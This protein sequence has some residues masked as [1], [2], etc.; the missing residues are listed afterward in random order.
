MKITGTKKLLILFFALT[1][2]LASALGVVIT[3][4]SASKGVAYAETAVS[5]PDV[6]EVTEEIAELEAEE[7]SK[8]DTFFEEEYDARYDED[9]IRKVAELLGR[10]YEAINLYC[11]ANEIDARELLA[12]LLEDE[13]KKAAEPA[14]PSFSVYVGHETTGEE[15]VSPEGTSNYSEDEAW[16]PFEEEEKTNADAIIS[17]LIDFQIAYTDG[18]ITLPEGSE[19]NDW[20]IAPDDLTT[21]ATTYYFMGYNFSTA[22]SQ[23]GWSFSSTQLRN[24][25]TIHHPE[26][27]DRLGG[28]W[29]SL[30]WQY[31]LELAPGETY[32]ITRPSANVTYN[33]GAAYG[34]NDHW[35][36]VL[37]YG[38][39]SEPSC[40]YVI[41]GDAPSG[42]V[43]YVGSTI[44][45][46]GNDNN[47]Y[48]GWQAYYSWYAADANR[49]YR[50][51]VADNNGAFNNY[52]TRC[53]KQISFKFV[54]KRT[55][56]V[57]PELVDDTATNGG[58]VNLSTKTKTAYYEG[59]PVVITMSHD[60]GAGIIG[61]TYDD[62]VTLKSRSQHGMDNGGTASP[63]SQLNGKNIEFQC[64]TAGTH[65]IKIKLLQPTVTQI[66]WPSVNNT[67]NSM[68]AGTMV[69]T[70]MNWKD[71]SGNAMSVT[72][73]SFTLKIEL[74]STTKPTMVRDDGVDG[75]GQTKT[76]NYTGGEQKISF[77]NADPDFVGWSSNGLVQDS[78]DPTTKV[79]VLK[80]TERGT[81]TI[82]LYL[83]NPAG[84]VWDGDG[85]TDTLQFNFFIKE[86]LIERPTMV[87]STSYNKTVK[88]SGGEQYLKVA[89]A[90][91]DQLVIIAAGIKY[92]PADEDGDGVNETIVF[93]MTDAG[94]VY[95][96]LSPAEGYIWSDK[97]SDT[98]TFT[99]TIE[100]VEVSVPKLLGGGTTKTVTFNPEKDWAA[101]LVILDIPRDAIA[102]TTALQFNRDADWLPKDVYNGTVAIEDM[103]SQ[104]Y[105]EYDY[106][107]LKLYASN[108]NTY[109]V[110]FS[111]TSTNYRWPD[112]AKVPTF[113]LTIN[114]YA[115]QTPKISDYEYT[116]N[117]D[118]IEGSTKTIY[119]NTDSTS[120]NY[121]D[122]A[123]KYFKLYAGG[124]TSNK[125]VT[126]RYSME[127]LREEWPDETAPN[128]TLWGTTLGG[129][130][131]PAGNYIIYI[132]PTS[133]YIWDTGNDDMYTFK[134]VITPI[135]RDQLRMYVQQGAGS[136]WVVDGGDRTGS[137][138][139]DGTEKFF[140]IGTPD[141]A[142]QF[143]YDSEATYQ[144]VNQ[145]HEP[146]SSFGGFTM[147]VKNDYPDLDGK[148]PSVL[149][150]SA[151][152]AGV[153]I[154][155]LQLRNTNYAWR[156]GSG[157]DIFY[158]FTIKAQSIKDPIILPQECS[159]HDLKTYDTY[160]HCGYNGFA[161]QLV[162]GLSDVKNS[163]GESIVKV[164]TN[165]SGTD[166]DEDGNDALK[167]LSWGEGTQEDIGRLI[168][169]AVVVGDHKVLLMIEDTNFRWETDCEYYEFELRIDYAEVDDVV[170]NYGL[171]DD[172]TEIGGNGERWEEE[173][174]PEASHF[175]TVTR[176]S[177]EFKGTAF[178]S[179]F[180]VEVSC[181]D[182]AYAERQIIT[183]DDNFVIEFYDANIYYISIYLTSNYRWRSNHRS[184]TAVQLT[185]QLYAK[186]VALPQIADNEANASVNNST[187][188]KTVTYDT[189]KSQNITLIF[190][191]D[192]KAYAVDES[193]IQPLGALKQDK[194]VVISQSKM[195]RYTAV[196]AGSYVLALT[197]S[198]TNNYAWASGDDTVFYTLKIEQRA[199]P[200]PDAFYIDA[201]DLN[202][203]H[204]DYADIKS[205]VKGEQILE[206][207][208]EYKKEVIY[209]ADLNYIYLFGYAIENK[210][211]TVEVTPLNPDNVNGKDQGYVSVGGE[212]KGYYVFAKTVNVYTISVKFNLNTEFGKPNCHWAGVSAGIDTDPRDYILVIT[213]KGLDLPEI[214][215]APQAWTDN[216]ISKHFTYDGAATGPSIDVTNCLSSTDS[217]PFMHYD[218]DT[219]RTGY[220]LDNSTH[221]LTFSILKT[222]N[223]GVDY[224]LTIS[225]DEAN[226]YWNTGVPGD[227]SDVDDKYVSIIID[228]KEINKPTVVDTGDGVVGKVVYD[229]QNLPD[230]LWKSV[231]YNASV[232]TDELRVTGFDSKWMTWKPSDF[233]TTREDT[234]GDLLLSTTRSDVGTYSVIVTLRD[235]TNFKWASTADD[236]DDRLLSLI[237]EPKKIAKPS[238]VISDSSLDPTD[239]TITSS[240]GNTTY[241][242]ATSIYIRDYVN[243]TN[244][245]DPKGVVQKIVI[246]NFLFNDP[247]G[248]MKVTTVSTDKFSDSED[249][250]TNEL[251]IYKAV[252]AGTYKLKFSL[253][254]NVAWD[255]GTGTDDYFITL[256]ISKREYK[257][258]T[259]DDPGA[260]LPI[261][262]ITVSADGLTKTLTYNFKAQQMVIND[263]DVNIMKWDGTTPDPTTGK[264]LEDKG[265][266]VVGTMTTYTF[267]ATDAGTYTATFS[268]RNF[269]NE[270]W[271]GITDSNITFTFKI[272]K[273]AIAIPEID[274]SVDFLLNGET[275][276]NTEFKV[277]Y[278]TLRHS[279]LALNVLDEN[280]MTFAMGGDYNDTVSDTFQVS[281]RVDRS[282]TGTDPG[283]YTY[284]SV[285]Q[286]FGTTKRDGEFQNTSITT[287]SD[288]DRVNFIL[289]QATEP[290]TYDVVFTLVDTLNIE[291]DDSTVANKKVTFKIE[292]V[293]LT[294][295]TYKVG[296]ANSQTY[297]GKPLKFYVANANNNVATLGAVPAFYYE[298]ASY[299]CTTEQSNKIELVS[300][301]GSELIVQATNYGTYEVKV[302]RNTKYV[303]WTDI[304]TPVKTFT[305]Y[306]TQAEIVP[307][308]T[309]GDAIFA[310]GV[311]GPIGTSDSYTNGLLATGGTAWAKS[312]T[313]TATVKLP[314]LS[315]KAA[316]GE[317]D[318]DGLQIE[319]YY[320]NTGKPTQK[321]HSDST[322]L[323]FAPPS[324]IIDATTI[325]GLVAGDPTDGIK[326]STA[327]PN[328]SIELT[329]ANEYN[330][331]YK[332][333]I[334]A[335]ADP[336]FNNGDGTLKKGTYKICVEQNNVSN[337]YTVRKV[338]KP[339]TIEADPAPFSTSNTEVNIIWEVYKASAPTTVHA[340]YVLAG[341]TYT[342]WYKTG[343]AG[344]MMPTDAIE[345]PYLE[346][347]SYFFKVNFDATGLQGPNTLIL[348]ATNFMDA[349]D[350]WEV[351]WD[352]VYGGTSSARYASKIGTTPTPYE[353]SITLK[354]KD[355]DAFSFTDT[356]FKFFYHITP[357][358]YDL[359]GIEWD[360]D[361]TPF[362][363]DGTAH[364]VKLK[365]LPAGLSVASYDVTGHDRN[366]QIYAKSVADHGT[367]EYYETHV[368]F[369]TSNKNYV[370]PVEGDNATYTDTSPAGSGFEWYVRW[371]IEK[372]TINVVWDNKLNEDGTSS[373]YIPRL[374]YDS[375]KVN[376]TYFM[377]DGS[378]SVNHTNWPAVTSFAHSGTVDFKVVATLKTNADDPALDYDNNYKFDTDNFLIFP[379]G[380]S[381]QISVDLF[382]GNIKDDGTPDI[383]SFKQITFGDTPDEATNV[384]T[385][386]YNEKPFEIYLQPEGTTDTTGVATALNGVPTKPGTSDPTID[387]W[388]NI[389]ITYY[390]TVNKFRPISA[391]T[392][393]GHYIV[394]LQFKNLPDDGNSYELA[395]TE[396]YFD[397]V[398]GTIDPDT[399]YWRYTHTDKDGKS[400]EARYDF[401]NE[402]WYI[403]HTSDSIDN[404]DG[405][406]SDP[407]GL[408]VPEIG[409]QIT[410]F[411]FDSR[412]H[413]VE[414][415]SE[416]TS[417][418]DARTKGAN[419]TRA[420]DYKSTVSFSYNGKLWNAPSIPTTFEWTIEKA[421]ISLADVKWTDSTGFVYTVSGGEVKTFTMTVTGIDPLLLSFI[422]YVTKDA[423][424]EVVKDSD[425]KPTNT[426]SN[427]GSYTTELIIDEGFD[428][429]NPDYKLG[430]DWP[431][432]VL[433]P[434]PW[435]IARRE[436]VVPS[437]NG[438]WTEFDGNQHDLLE[439]ITIDDDWAEYFTFTINYKDFTTTSSVDYFPLGVKEFGN[440]YFA[441]HAGDYEFTFKLIETW[442]ASN[443][444]VVWKTH[445]GFTFV[446]TQDD[447]DSLLTIN[448][449]TMSLTSWNQND[450]S[451]TANL[452]GTYAFDYNQF[453]DYKYYLNGTGFAAPAIDPTEANLTP[454]ELI[455]VLSIVTD[456]E[457]VIEV[458]VRDTFAK[459]IEL[460]N[461]GTNAVRLAFLMQAPSTLMADQQI[462][463]KYPYIKGYVSDGSET[464]FTDSDWK[465]MFIADGRFGDVTDMDAWYEDLQLNDPEKLATYKS[466][467]RVSVTYDG[468]PVT[469]LINDW[470]DGVKYNGHLNIW[471]GN[472]T[473][474]AAGDYS[475]TL[476]FIKDVTNPRCWSAVDNDGDG[477]ADDIDRS[478]LTLS[479]RI[480]F[481]VIDPHEKEILAN[482]PTYT[483]SQIDI[484]QYALGEAAYDEW[485]AQYGKYFEIVG[486]KGTDAGSYTLQ[487]KIKEEYI[488]TIHWANDTPNGQPGTYTIKWKIKPIY[489]VDPLALRG[490]TS[491]VVY[492]GDEHF[493]YETLGY[494]NG[495]DA[496]KDI[497]GLKQ[498]V[499]IVGASGVDAGDYTA[500]FTLLNDNYAWWN[501]TN[502][503]ESSDKDPKRK[504]E[505]KITPKPLDMSK[506]KW[507]YT[508]PYQYSI[509]ANGDPTEYEV[510]LTDI[511]EELNDF[512]SYLTDENTVN[513]RTSMGKYRTV[514]YLFE[515]DVRQSA[516]YSLVNIPNQ[517]RL[518]YPDPAG[519]G[520]ASIQWEII[521]HRFTIPTDITVDFS[522]TLR[523]IVEDETLFGFED[524]WENYLEVGILYKEYGTDDD[525]YASYYEIASVDEALDYSMFNVLYAGDYKVTFTIKSELNAT[526]EC[527]VWYDGNNHTGDQT[528]VLTV[529]P[530][531]IKI[532]GWAPVMDGDGVTQLTAT[533][534]SA[535]FD[536]MTQESKDLFTYVVRDKDTGEVIEDLAEVKA[537]GNGIY[538][539]VEFK[540]IDGDS[541]AA[542]C[543]F[544]L[545]WETN[546]N[547]PY[548]FINENYGSQP[549]IWIPMPKLVTTASDTY[550]GKPK[551]YTIVNSEAYELTADMKTALDGYGVDV[552][553]FDN[554][555]Q[556]I[557]KNAGLVNLEDGVVTIT[558]AG[559]FE[560]MFRALANV[561]ISWFDPDDYEVDAATGKLCY[562]GGSALSDTEIA[563]KKLINR[564]AQ[565]VD[566][567]IKKASVDYITPEMLEQYAAMIPDLEY[568]GK[569]YNLKTLEDTKPLF[570]LL[571]RT[572]G[573][574]I[575]FEGFTA[576]DAGEHILKISLTDPTSSYWNL[577]AKETIIVND[578]NYSG[579]DSSFQLKYVKIDGKWDVR[580]VDADGNE[581]N[582]GDYKVEKVYKMIKLIDSYVALDG[583]LD[584]D[585][586]PLEDGKYEVDE[587]GVAVRY[588][589]IAGN[590]VASNDGT[591]IAKLKLRADGSVAEMPELDA[592]G[593]TAIDVEKTLVKVTR[594]KTSTDPYEITWR[595]TTSTL[596]A[597]TVN[598]D[599]VL[600]FNGAEQRVESV[601]KGFNATYM[602][603][604][605]G[606]V[607]KDA[608]T[609]TAKIGIKDDN[610]V[611][612]D[613]SEFVYVTWKIE[614]AIIDWTGVTWKFTDGTK[615]YKNGAGMVY[616]RVNGKATV[617]WVELANLPQALQGS[618]KYTTNGVPGAYAGRDAGKYVTMFD[619]DKKDKNFENLTIPESLASIEWSIQ[620][621]EISV[622]ELGSTQFIFD[623]GTHDLFSMLK[624]PDN[625][626]EYIDINVLYASNF[627]TFVTYG[628]HNGNPYE[629]YGA[630]A[631]KF[632]VSFKDGINVNKNN[633]SVIWAKSSSGELLPTV[634]VNEATKLLKNDTTE[635]VKE[636]AKAPAKKVVAAEEVAIETVTV[637]ETKTV[638]A[639]RPHAEAPATVTEIQRVCDRIKRLV[640][641]TESQ[642]KDFRKQY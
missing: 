510:K 195:V 13:A 425:G 415:F 596:A 59:S 149:M 515:N 263:Y 456:T 48:Y 527:I 367:G 206:V 328:W 270:C 638:P 603:I 330:L 203:L 319:I 238:I 459:D 579:Y 53:A 17:D 32:T 438:K 558:K 214:V 557:G 449:A 496:T 631:Y 291:W 75:Y 178:N 441:S 348:P 468:A 310:T 331:Y 382:V 463:P 137:A 18:E 376:Y 215:G 151:I 621:R 605:E 601:L 277:T 327:D 634:P 250:T 604:I 507:D 239:G 228:K 408:P 10:K 193:Q 165:A 82:N 69:P 335:D 42:T 404:G 588:A 92:D 584:D 11:H 253:T 472:L 479:F 332:Y 122:N 88:Y 168:L 589:L 460:D 571:D 170:F 414:L 626:E 381:M 299:S 360:Y 407:A 528:A 347:D 106:D 271:T 607:G 303:D 620:R 567:T 74:Q 297:E 261:P 546:V 50:N 6:E 370:I 324:D 368:E 111:L 145:A 600:R 231:I 630:G 439:A 108:A 27:A 453:V 121:T 251:L 198:N 22:A 26:T 369:T 283:P 575:T 428:A 379:L 314:K 508:G 346:N 377:D 57:A 375:N 616:T 266:A 221:I 334:I 275:A 410:E 342:N 300:W 474:N 148:K 341:A 555:I 551:V 279:V 269:R 226:E 585:G 128:L 516:N 519:F 152:E 431:A 176:S 219:S 25:R 490:K 110:Q 113:Y 54:V 220:T 532:T 286:V 391:P 513:T 345:L 487:L 248:T 445:N 64:S 554:L 442:N 3:R 321:L 292:K 580:Y 497:A 40:K 85:S 130:S 183:N 419:G 276:T 488:S 504:I 118:K 66:S 159:G 139:Y 169:S 434:M 392:D 336:T 395:M 409:Q 7:A 501:P 581:Y 418:L 632:V 41:D 209:D 65:V 610:Y 323:V 260:L 521:P 2:L 89:P 61:Y 357:I 213:K 406:W 167:L 533:I 182:S 160:I 58:A 359:K 117:R 618:I 153:Y 77:R 417:I 240:A 399:Y 227:M 443:E 230:I 343:A 559:D 432:S 568:T 147:G 175:I 492:S 489:V 164:F 413:T 627:I 577:K 20:Y 211:V 47:Q 5:A 561:N 608:D 71:S 63:T 78:W 482:L 83:K 185:F 243:T 307:E 272:E 499:N 293:K 400:Y 540:L 301:Y 384:N 477:V 212:T 565:S 80:Q 536:A 90:D 337:S 201:D 172:M 192:Y 150:C 537:R 237:V 217:R 531:E 506:V 23:M 636:L 358:L 366:V 241:D 28:N 125:Q 242:T 457:F 641:C 43:F 274:T 639:V 322:K 45:N 233:A 68:T 416:N 539:T 440:K 123:D 55:A 427:A 91:V 363:Y 305:F 224:T 124:F 597:P 390:S 267:E 583:L 166:V 594:T 420:G 402:A 543:G 612:R 136:A 254:G 33:T 446:Y 622:P 281:D 246:E 99:F 285:S 372:A 320:F 566:L 37:S 72:E 177:D 361:G 451:S 578:K 273:L 202:K 249:D 464:I 387:I 171:P 98:I 371:E 484:L 84:V 517:F 550:D 563:T 595:I 79:L 466:Q 329:A 174:N 396:F 265:T 268:L 625:W 131:G 282:F 15:Y 188:T 340:T 481:R 333:Q 473:Q 294:S 623:D 437:G 179:Q 119:Y 502:N 295:P 389:V 609:Y 435:T 12:L 76:V 617:Y 236:S 104:G 39:R 4:S 138:D 218:Y 352:G 133:N 383:P 380:P 126:I 635:A 194:T 35:A 426:L 467:I 592:E 190:G 95:I 483:G 225:L 524:G 73:I 470:E 315:V 229:D 628:G 450:E 411:V 572:Y 615:D 354:A 141:S 184:D 264:A 518:D 452:T 349:L 223:V 129:A 385:V 114:R 46:N 162:I 509:D 505:W 454:V 187:R 51:G 548:E 101:E 191:N 525:K 232:W 158:T 14:E 520:F 547:N 97:K 593:R 429:A 16:P 157:V 455:D 574:L 257:P 284:N 486:S 564:S 96:K 530:K 619:V 161:A 208:G 598:E 56:P 247:D 512:I 475:V 538:Y 135:Y 103:A 173:F 412:T 31:D 288:V 306:I 298:T 447:Q 503:E 258:L 364:T 156:D 180:R 556:A 378:G 602:E 393:P 545:V 316:T 338:D 624:L 289:L 287:G 365:N 234:N 613:G 582:N 476:M 541:Y 498:Y 140:R 280:Y 611:W 398:K 388:N 70:R 255:D 109:P 199:I 93:K 586:K 115:L 24:A 637:E 478:P 424:G 480:S 590:Y 200:V 38:W 222:A 8:E 353:V 186:F 549:V 142:S 423:S 493:V 311:G 21:Y 569:E 116:N 36:Y 100:A 462:V 52:A 262:E 403:H 235:T 448:K 244:L 485:I 67:P 350:R 599:I 494:E 570:D 309:Y 576:T 216:K 542:K 422:S 355:P 421:T 606:G 154:V 112:G 197:L 511:P 514:V 386:I 9:V 107:V 433:N 296:A 94:T 469:F 155:R 544:E 562:K 312:R 614:K 344:E 640:C 526:E 317:L 34:A 134:F 339:F 401:V 629:A 529:K 49:T 189:G 356:T 102:V 245:N 143:F 465:Q 29:S 397:I 196:N 394:K 326:V 552:S 534:T 461:A 491:S 19:D 444:N 642:L 325:S 405:T 304:T 205:G 163:N 522:G 373:A 278:D 86:M 633:P 313:V 210:E 318:V 132:T 573:K 204:E 430:D 471:Q 62:T 60:F 259:I 362:V 30:Y 207:A 351:K 523:D 302:Y 560:I 181:V 591:Y 105:T 120:G 127:G 1:C 500:Y 146:T 81:Y 374:K 535:D 436:I 87:G 256:T 44:S 144:L 553:A 587:N 495:D 252:N 458:F 290:G 308:I